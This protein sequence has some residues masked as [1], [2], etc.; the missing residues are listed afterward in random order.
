MPGQG[1]MASSLACVVIASITASAFGVANFG[2]AVGRGGAPAKRLLFKTADEGQNWEEVD[3]S[4]SIP[5]TADD[6]WARSVY[7]LDSTTGWVGGEDYLMKTSNGGETWDAK[8]SAAV[9]GLAS[10][11][12]AGFSRITFTTASIGWV[13]G[14]ILPSGQRSST[15]TTAFIAKT[16]DGGET[17]QMLQNVGT[18]AECNLIGAYFHDESTGY[19]WGFKTGTTGYEGTVAKTNDGGSSWTKLASASDQAF[20]LY[21]MKGGWVSQQTGWA[22]AMSGTSSWTKGKLLKTTDGGASWTEQDSQTG[23]TLQAMYFHDATTGWVV[24]DKGA[25]AKTTD[26]GL[27]WN[28]QTSTSTRRLNNV[29]FMNIDVGIV[30]G[31]YGIMLR[32]NDGGA[33]W[34]GSEKIDPRPSFSRSGMSF[35]RAASAPGTTVTSSGAAAG[36]TSGTG[37]ASGAA[38]TTSA[39]SLTSGATNGAIKTHAWKLAF[40]G[41]MSGLLRV[42][43]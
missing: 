28:Q 16:N 37:T 11:K 41:I 9:L 23:Q 30:V 10:G 34:T 43:S 8:A 1:L 22:L 26:G 17:W 20:S 6:G 31:E 38:S 40:A 29:E 36:A 14:N 35:A 25:I 33:T 27:T 12:W 4:S 21:E 2:W 15:D 18:I 32:T 24:G 5:D 7:F 13:T 39:S 42:L 3:I 19:A